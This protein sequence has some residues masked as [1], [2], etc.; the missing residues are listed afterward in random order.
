MLTATLPPAANLQ[1]PGLPVRSTS[2]M[3]KP[4]SLY[5]VLAVTVAFGTPA[6]AQTTPGYTQA[7]VQFMKAMI[8]PHA[9]A[10]AMVAMIPSRTTRPDLRALV[11][12]SSFA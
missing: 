7:D 1:L 12:Q 11:E 5:A 3:P 10:L 8:G 6:A 4:L 9:H 2:V